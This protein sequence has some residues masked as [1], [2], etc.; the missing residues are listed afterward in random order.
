MRNPMFSA[1]VILLGLSAAWSGVRAQVPLSTAFTYQGQLK[2]GGVP[3]N[4]DY[5]FRFRLFDAPN[6]GEPVGGNVAPMTLPV[7]NG[8][9]TAEL[10]FG[11]DTFNGEARWLEVAVRA[12]DA[13]GDHTIL[14]P[15]QP[16]TTAPYALYALDVPSG[17][18]GYWAA[19][20][21]DIYNT[22]SGRVG[23]GTPAPAMKMEVQAATSGDGLRVTAM[24]PTGAR[25]D[26]KGFLLPPLAVGL[27]GSIN[28][29][30]YDDTVFGGIEYWYSQNDLHGLPRIDEMKFTLG[31]EERM[32]I[33]VQE[34]SARTTLETSLG[35]KSG[36]DAALAGGGYLTLGSIQGGNL[37]LDN[38][39]IMARDDGEASTLYLNNDGGYI[40]LAGNSQYGRVGIGTTS[41][42]HRLEVHGNG[43]T[44]DPAVRIAN[45]YGGG[46]S[47]ETNSDSTPGVYIHNEGSDYGLKVYSTDYTAAQF[48]SIGRTALSANSIGTADPA[49]IITHSGPGKALMVSGS[50]EVDVLYIA[51]SDVA[52][53]F[54]A[55]E[56][57]KPGM[58][59][60]I[61]P[62]NPG[63]LRLSREA[64]DRCVAGVVSGANGFPAGAVLGSVL[65]DDNAQAIALSGRVWVYC[66][67][68]NQPIT[69]GD[70]LTT[71]ATPGHAMKATDHRKAQGAVL[72][73]AMT[74]LANG[75][76]LV[77]VLVS[78]Q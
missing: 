28:F 20:E 76:G 43:S 27:L 48:L 8:L 74:S 11:R 71:A 64:Y 15:R 65:G 47:V 17:A 38:N 25:L 21:D 16:L 18:G 36:T 7:V 37:A 23:V 78:L 57:A 1:L 13:G 39:E 5:D 44:G 42:D 6:G 22:N 2:S 31:A 26:L 70:L 67:A 12:T 34:G 32:R 59:M 46:L 50:A 53:K 41:P 29:L 54:P 35:V 56:Q 73:K 61:D 51:G 52:E 72:G 66:D 55:S 69:P 75:C 58:V 19:D 3:V 10:D 9:F 33:V 14:S 63:R 30:N 62:K 40:C 24:D 49:V 77:L 4:G 68:T 60:A 45:D